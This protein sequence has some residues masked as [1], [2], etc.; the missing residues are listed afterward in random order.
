M[1][2]DIAYSSPSNTFDI[3][4]SPR[5]GSYWATDVVMH[6]ADAAWWQVDLTKLTTVGRVVV[7]CYYG[8]KRY[9]GFT[10]E[11]SP[12]GKTWETVANRRDNRELS[13]RQG[14]T[15]KFEP[16]KARYLRVTQPHNSANTGRHLVEVMA[17]EE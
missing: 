1:K 11:T 6:K 10:V 7:I 3:T 2:C 14:Y 9:D 17:F 4:P 15:C 16:R 5:T 8:D 13:T 12:D